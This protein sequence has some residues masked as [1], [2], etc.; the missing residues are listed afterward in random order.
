MTRI[1]TIA[2]LLGLTMT[3][4][5]AWAAKPKMLVQDLVAQGVE[6]HEAQV[7][8]T[9]TC[10]A[11]SKTA[12]YDVL[13]G[14]DLRNMMRFGALAASFDTCADASCYSSMGKAM[15]ARF[16]VSGTISRL[17][18]T[19]VMSLSMIDTETARPVG[20]TELKADSIEKLH[21]QATEAASAILTNR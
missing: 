5:P 15:Q 9:A 13:C 11:I 18:K 4:A 19:F 2:L 20:R 21:T 10:N 3:S 17:G 1:A 8:S 14:D 12:K 7:I 16:I 6:A